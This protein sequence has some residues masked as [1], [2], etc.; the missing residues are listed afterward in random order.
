MSDDDSMDIV[1]RDGMRI[2]FLE[3]ECERLRV[4]LADAMV[5]VVNGDYHNG[6]T[7]PT[8]CID[9]G[10]FHAGQ[11]I[12]ALVNGCSEIGLVYGPTIYDNRQRA[13]RAAGGGDG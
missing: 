12:Q 6:V 1:D 9:E 3:A 2:G 5:M 7:D 4:L 10:S 11:V 8:G 13:A